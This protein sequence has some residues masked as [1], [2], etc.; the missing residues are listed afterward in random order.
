MFVRRAAIAFSLK[1]DA[2]RPGAPPERDSTAVSSQ[3]FVSGPR[4]VVATRRS[5]KPARTDHSGIAICMNRRPG[6]SR[7]HARG[8]RPPFTT[9][10]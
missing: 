8:I 5:V 10:A 7:T 3:N 2:R 4:P 6:I 9:G 1:P